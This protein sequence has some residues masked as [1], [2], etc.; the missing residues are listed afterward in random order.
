MSD[1]TDTK[2]VD[3]D[4]VDPA[5]N[6]IGAAGQSA[7]P[8]VGRPVSGMPVGGPHNL[9]KE[10]HERADDEADDRAADQSE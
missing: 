9:G 8:F 2:P 1:P 7:D 4:A 3:D 5:I 6:A 10:A